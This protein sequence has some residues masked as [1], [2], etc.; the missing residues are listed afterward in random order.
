MVGTLPIFGTVTPD[1][2]VPIH[3]RSPRFSETTAGPF[4]I[5]SVC[6]ESGG[7]IEPHHHDRPNVGVMLDGSFDLTFGNRQYECTPGTLF[8]E[9]AGETHCNCMGCHG[10]AVIALQPDPQAPALGGVLSNVFDRPA[11]K[12]HGPALRIARRIAVESSR[13]D[14]FSPLMVQ[15]LA[16]E[17]LAM[18]ARGTTHTR[19]MPK[20]WL[21]RIEA[22]L[23]DLPPDR[24]SIDELAREAG[25]H[26]AHLAREF[27][28]QFGR[29]LGGYL[30]ER[31]LDW[32]SRALTSTS[33]PISEIALEAGFADQS[34]FTRRFRDYTGET[35]RQFR[36]ARRS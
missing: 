24:I 21:T 23:R 34:H 29:S 31:R 12:W 36:V 22:M 3:H 18:V 10:A 6:F 1:P 26:A 35:P 9:P 25:V 16:F 7:V 20:A 2:L 8:I 4:R 27:R 14:E 19:R 11:A 28:K 17:L 15:G 30:L 33:R 5:T 13:T 32:A